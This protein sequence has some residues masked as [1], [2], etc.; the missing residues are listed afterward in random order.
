MFIHILYYC[1]LKKPVGYYLTVVMSFSHPIVSAECTS[2]W[3]IKVLKVQC[4]CFCI[5]IKLFLGNNWRL[6]LLNYVTTDIEIPDFALKQSHTVS[7][8]GFASHCYSV[9]ARGP[10]QLRIYWWCHHTGQ[11]SIPPKQPELFKQHLHF[12]PHSMEIFIKHT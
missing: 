6:T 2:P 9:V 1:I 5:N 12:Q 7:A 8:H 4:S 3:R 11:N 10:N